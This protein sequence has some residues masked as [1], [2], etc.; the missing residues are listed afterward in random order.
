MPK[1]LC[2]EQAK[3]PTVTIGMPVFNG[4]RFIRKALDSAL[5]QTFS[6]FEIIISDNNSNDATQTI[7]CEYAARDSRINYIRHEKNF[8]VHWNF[9]FVARRATGRFYTWLAHDD[10]LE[11]QFLD[12][13][14]RYMF[15]NPG[16]VLAAC[17]FA[18]IDENGTEL[19]FEKLETLRDSLAW[20][21]RRVPFFA[22]GHS[23]IYF[24]TYGM[25]QTA[26]CKSIIADV[27]ERKML[28]GSEYPI[29][30][31]FAASGEITSLPFV[32]R[33]HRSHSSSAFQTE[34]R[35]NMQRDKLSR[36]AFFYSNLFVMRVDLFKVVLG[37]ALTT[38]DKIKILR[39]HMFNDLKWFR[40]KM[41]E[42]FSI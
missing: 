2:D 8:G 10:T 36:I 30:A 35:E 22:Y 31:R 20:E 29:I 26:I 41:G 32:L 6:D 12:L 17:D 14:V 23:N 37:S 7:C 18:I 39:W 34:T 25:M 38:R 27:K 40:S 19:R 24:C 42:L 4:E 1:A 5:N 21:D 15:Q 9:S 3:T 33:T 13:T 28:A 16:T 11:P